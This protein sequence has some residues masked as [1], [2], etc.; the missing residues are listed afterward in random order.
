[1]FKSRLYTF[2]IF[3]VLAG[4]SGT[5]TMDVANLLLV[6]FGYGYE[7]NYNFIA[8]LVRGWISGKFVYAAPTDVYPL[9]A[10]YIFGFFWHYLIGIIFAVPASLIF[11]SKM[12]K[13]L[14]WVVAYGAATSLVSLTLLFPSIGIGFFAS[15]TP[16]PWLFVSTNL[17]NH[18]FFGVGMS[19]T[20]Y[21]FRFIIMDGSFNAT[22]S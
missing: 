3:A 21:L 14:L 5:A 19:A 10:D 22:Y 8:A 20:I 13:K 1:M 15:H 2:L 11:L 17:Y 6:Y 4:I 16:T 18:V 12:Q 7:I 9:A